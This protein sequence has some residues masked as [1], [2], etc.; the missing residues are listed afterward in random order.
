M[1][2]PPNCCSTDYW[3]GKD[4]EA[5][6]SQET[7]C[8]SFALGVNELTWVRQPSPESMGMSHSKFCSRLKFRKIAV[9]CNNLS[10]KPTLFLILQISPNVIS[11]QA[12]LRLS[13]TALSKLFKD[14]EDLETKHNILLQS[15][16]IEMCSTFEKSSKVTK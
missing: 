1:L 12:Q 9:N 13:S 2:Q 14:L 4:S 6:T 5:R 16:C 7:F 15:F 10:F 3:K 11:A 8:M